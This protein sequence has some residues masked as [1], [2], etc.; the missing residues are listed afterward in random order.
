[1]ISSTAV[2]GIGVIAFGMVITPGPNM[3]HLASRSISQGR[4]AGL[5]SLGG[6][7]VGFSATSLLR[8][9]DCRRSSNGCRRHTPS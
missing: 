5:I 1:M 9:A 4:S 3:V 7:A 6:V 2:V 8:P